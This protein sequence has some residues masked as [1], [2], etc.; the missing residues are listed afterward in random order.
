MPLHPRIRFEVTVFL[1]YVAVFACLDTERGFRAAARLIRW[2]GAR[3]RDLGNWAY[4]QAIHSDNA[5]KELM[6]P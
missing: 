4:T 5:Y 6:A 2:Y 3:C 1:L